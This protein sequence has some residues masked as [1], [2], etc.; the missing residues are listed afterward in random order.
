L[1]VRGKERARGGTGQ[2]TKLDNRGTKSCAR[3]RDVGKGKHEKGTLARPA[4]WESSGKERVDIW[5]N[6]P[7][8]AVARTREARGQTKENLT[9]RQA[10][11]ARRT[12]SRDRIAMV[13]VALKGP[14]VISGR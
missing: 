5:T 10:T 9:P 1:P 11:R 14:G 8:L 7:N 12:W 4:R 6:D 13:T 2:K 3:T